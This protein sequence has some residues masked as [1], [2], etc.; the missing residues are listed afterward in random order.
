MEQKAS[1]NSSWL[2]KNESD[3]ECYKKSLHESLKTCSSQL[4]L[5]EPCYMKE[6]KEFKEFKQ[7]MFN[8]IV[9]RAF[10]VYIV[11]IIS[12]IYFYQKLVKLSVKNHYILSTL[13]TKKIIVIFLIFNAIFGLILYI[14]Y[15][16]YKISVK[17]VP[18]LCGEYNYATKFVSENCYYD[19]FKCYS[20]PKMFKYAPELL[21]NFLFYGFIALFNFTLFIAYQDFR[22][23]EYEL[24]KML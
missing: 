21:V 5:R 23:Y 2:E 3:L 6:M 8:L 24:Y 19:S 9:L 20:F 11:T 12:L 13:H 7:E 1:Q 22:R 16:K 18:L 15:G 10:A 14:Q 17:D 4:K